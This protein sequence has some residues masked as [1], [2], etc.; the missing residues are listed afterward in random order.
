MFVKTVCNKAGSFL[1]PIPVGIRTTLKYGA[2]GEFDKAFIGF[3]DSKKESDE[4]TALCICNDTVVNKIPIKGGTTYVEGVLYTDTLFHGSGELPNCVESSMINAG[5]ANSSNFAFWAGNVYSLAA[6][7]RG[8]YAIRQWL[9]MAKFSVIPGFII[10]VNLNEEMFASLL[11]S[12]KYP[13]KIPFISSYIVHTGLECNHVSTGMHQHI[14]NVMNTDLS[15]DGTIK[16]KLIC[17]GYERD[18]DYSKVVMYNIT[19]H[20]SIVVDYFGRLCACVQNN[21]SRIMPSK[22]LSCRVCEKTIP[23]LLDKVT[24]CRDEKCP[25]RLYTSIKHFI[26]TLGLPT[27]DFEDFQKLVYKHKLFCLLDIFSLD[28]YSQLNISCNLDK[29]IRACV[30]FEVCPDQNVFTL[31]CNRCANN[32]KNV[33]YYL[34]NPQKIHADLDI[35]SVFLRKLTEWLSDSENVSTVVAAVEN[36][37]IAVQGVG[38]AFDG[39]PIFRDKK[40]C[41]TGKFS[42]G[43]MSKMISILSSYSATVVTALDS[44]TD[45]VVLGSTLEDID[46]TIVSAAKNSRIPV[47][48]ETVFFKNY[49]IDS[50]IQNLL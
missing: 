6:S 45:C 38:R 20:S 27:L 14:V 32:W 18:V 25:S 5:L 41:I 40:I 17:E 7:F 22:V 11:R 29:L 43:S 19:I 2:S 1:T 10:P 28:I 15:D 46:N 12:I 35:H 30:P 9:S 23:V 26:D 21:R 31:I 47:Y 3:G 33:E 49:D 50:D 39:A 8:S 13:F 34:N 42:H 48:D 44:D 36:E 24:M 16:T 37:H 4:L